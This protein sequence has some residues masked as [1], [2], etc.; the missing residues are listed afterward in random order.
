LCAVAAAEMKIGTHYWQQ[1][2]EKFTIFD[3]FVRRTAKRAQLC[4]QLAL[5]AV[6]P[7][8]VTDAA[9]GRGAAGR[10]HPDWRFA[11]ASAYR[12]CKFKPDQRTHTV[13]KYRE[14]P[15]KVWLNVLKQ[16]IDK[17]GPIIQR[18]PRVTRPAAR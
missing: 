1:D 11:V 15:R 18:R 13:T 3:Q 7:L 12:V 9:G 14:G 16:H 2:V 10:T 4:E 6:A 8:Q 17:H 5:G